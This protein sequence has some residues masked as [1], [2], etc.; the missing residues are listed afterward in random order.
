[1]IRRHLFA[2][3]LLL[4]AAD[5][6]IAV[7]I[8]RV[9]GQLRFGDAA[10]T[11]L[12]QAL[13]VN[14]VEGAV[15]YAVGWISILWFL[16]LYQ[17]RVRWTVS[18]EF[19]DMLAASFIMAFSV[20]SFLYLANLAVS[21]LF[22]LA[23][24]V[25]QPL[26][27]VASRLA[28]R[29]GFEWARRRGRNRSFMVIVGVGQEAQDFADA[30][31]RHAEL[32]IAVVG[33]LRAPGED[34]EVT[35]PILG[36]GDE[37]GRV[38]HQTVVDEVAVCVAPRAG[39]WAQPL[40]RLAADEG[41]RVRV[42]TRAEPRALDLA[43]EELDGLLV[44]SYVNGPTRMLSLAAKRTID[45]AGAVVGLVALSPVFAVTALAIL[46]REG[47]PV[48]YEQTRVG[49]HGRPFQL[50]KFRSMVR[51]ADERFAEVAHLNERYAIAYKAA[52]D[53]RI[54]P[55]GR[56]LRS[57][58]IDELPQLWNVLRGEMSLV[59]PRPPLPRE[60]RE[61]DIWHRRRLSMKPG[62]TGL[63]QVEA[64]GEADFDNCVQR[65]LQYIDGWSLGLDLR[66]L[67]KTVPA[68]VARTG[69]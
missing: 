6:V 49:L 44:R 63:W 13:H 68:V 38:L 48:L 1:M 67:A 57:T 56:V 7:V 43:V 34:D 9:L 21:R 30:V 37:L 33:H 24:L 45:L 19:N 11:T 42:P 65:D 16:G 25:C 31:E 40:I 3:R 32:G 39:D 66:I 69:K 62:I 28:M 36:E 50:H 12:W 18:G 59:G 23:L 41:K 14:G 61:Y 46:V 29:R 47:R 26:V 52:A 10:W 22:I 54:T 4:L 20:M 27:T 58:S 51:D 2:L 8:F 55:L 60:V 53:T 64:R 5:L 35:R 15:F 17:F